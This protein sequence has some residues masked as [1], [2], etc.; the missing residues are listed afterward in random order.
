MAVILSILLVPQLDFASVNQLQTRCESI[1]SLLYESA[2][3][4]CQ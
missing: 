4:G 1:L 2:S 3:E